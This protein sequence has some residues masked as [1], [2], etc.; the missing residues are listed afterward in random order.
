MGLSLL[1]RHFLGRSFTLGIYSLYSITASSVF[2]CDA[3]DWEHRSAEGRFFF[4]LRSMRCRRLEPQFCCLFCLLILFRPHWELVDRRGFFH[5]F[6][7]LEKK[8]K[9]KKK[10]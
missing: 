6:F 3:Q 4:P 2:L 9:K 7:W 8:K 1:F 5:W 10:K